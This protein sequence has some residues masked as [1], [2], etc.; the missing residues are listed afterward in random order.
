MDVESMTEAIDLSEY[1][2]RHGAAKAAGR[3]IKEIAE[4]L[5]QD[6]DLEVTVEKRDGR[7]GER[8]VVSWP[9]GP[10]DWATVLCGGESLF[11]GEMPS[12]RQGSNNPQIQGLMNNGQDWHVEC[13]DRSTL[14]FY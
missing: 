7:F 10:F 11:A 5:D 3:K 9:G 8:W 2:S 12:V 1:K 4:D 13:E 14:A 6:P